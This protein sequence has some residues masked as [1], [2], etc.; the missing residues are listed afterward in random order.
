MPAG[1]RGSVLAV[2]FSPDG[3][4][5]ASCS[6]DKTIRLWD[7]A[8]GELLRLLTEHTA[9]VY[10]LV[11]S[12][13]GDLLASG[14]R[15]KGIKLWDAQ[16]GKAIRTLEGHTDIVRSVAF[17]PDQRTLAS[18]SVDL[19][20]RLW[21]VQPGT[22]K[23]TLQGHTERVM[24][25]AF[26]PDGAW[27]ASAS[28]DKT[29]RVWDAR[30]GEL[31][32]LLEGHTGGLEHIDFS[33]DGKLLA[34]SSHDATVRLWDAARTGTARERSK[35]MMARSTPS[36]LAR[37]KDRGER[38]QGHIH[39]AL[40]RC[41]RQVASNADRPYWSRRREHDPIE[42]VG[43]ARR[44]AQRRPAVR[45][46][47]HADRRE[48][49]DLG[50]T[51]PQ[52][53][54][55]RRDLRLGPGDD[56]AP[57]GE[58]PPDRTG[59]PRPAGSGRQEPVAPFGEEL[60]SERGSDGGRV[61]A[62]AHGADEHV[63]VLAGDEAVQ[64]DRTARPVAGRVR[65]HRRVATAAEPG[66][67]G[68]FRGDRP[69]DEDVVDRPEDLDRRGVVLPAA[70]AERAL[71]HLGQHRLGRQDLGGPAEEAQPLERGDGDDDGPARRHPVEAGGDRA[72]QLGERQIGS[73]VRELGPPADGAGRDERPGPEL[74]KR[75]ADEGV[76]HV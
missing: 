2:A 36:I 13:K 20:V 55:E 71:S 16:T 21:D 69:C 22:L 1:H 67:E 17:S 27:L 73:E 30:T 56:D 65:S 39:Q 72:A 68:P 53:R 66:E 31:K 61:V 25:V 59:V 50:P 62:A 3:K 4:V 11:F 8:T 26:S 28:S 5:L 58:R 48:L 40:G 51:R 35:A 44:A 64:L 10:V 32:F 46:V 18:G 75:P 7:V 70:Q 63:P 29:A 57:A 14:G 9:D 38:G 33:P 41:D 43:R 42:P 6:R 54:G 47:L 76:A 45:R 24:S 19:T 52:R 15:D 60:F 34:S 37:R 12:P 74:A 23:R 49:D